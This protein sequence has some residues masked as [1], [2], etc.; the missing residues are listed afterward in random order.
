MEHVK[1][2]SLYSYLKFRRNR[3]IEENEAKKV[4]KS[5]LEGI[6]YLHLQNIAH[7]DLKPDNILLEDRYGSNKSLDF[8]VKIIDFGFSI[9]MQGQ[10]KLK[11]FCGTPSFM[12][13]EIVTK[14]DYCGKQADIWALGILLFSMVCGRCPFRA[15]N[16]RDLY[17]KIARGVFSFPDEFYSKADEYKDLK[18]SDKLKELIKKIL[19]VNPDKRPT[20]AEILKDEWFTN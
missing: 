12:A 9:S 15:E 5:L 4:F 7:R 19:V 1:G 8:T 20:C 11:T 13:P 16:E 10:K 14:K 3:R 2:K 6:N 18:I 17:R